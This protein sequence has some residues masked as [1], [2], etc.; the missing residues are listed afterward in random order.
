MIKV[1]DKVKPN[2]DTL[3][4]NDWWVNVKHLTGE[5]SVVAVDGNSIVFFT[6]ENI[7][8]HP[9]TP[10]KQKGCRCWNRKYLKAIKWYD[11]LEN[12]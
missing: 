4:Y 2:W 3:K 10:G 1:G 7:R 5:Y 11:S 12:K 6:G 9:G 8:P